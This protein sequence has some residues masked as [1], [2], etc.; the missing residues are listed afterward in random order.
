MKYFLILFFFLCNICLIRSDS[1]YVDGIERDY[2]VHLPKGFDESKNT[3]L[4]LALHGGGGKAK[5]MD[6]L[7]GF[8]NVS[9][10]YGFVVVYPEGIKKQ[11]NDGRDDFHLNEKIND[12]KFIS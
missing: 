8:N 11:W 10:K 12:V 5:G 9:D 2:I 3:P 7:T 4:V 6:K 1:I